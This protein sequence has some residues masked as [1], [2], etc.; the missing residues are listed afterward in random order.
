V[1]A[2][3]ERGA[4]TVKRR[5]AF[6]LAWGTCALT[7]VLTV[8]IVV[9]AVLSHRGFDYAS[10]SIVG[11]SSAVVGAVVASKRPANIVG[12]LFLFAALLSTSQELAAG[13]AVYGIL[14]DPSA[15][16]L[17][18]AAA[19]FSNAIEMVGPLLIFILIPLYF[20]TGRPVSRRWGLVAW[21]ALGVL[22]VVTLLVD[23]RYRRA[24]HPAAP[25]HP[26][27]HRPPLL[28][29]QIRRGADARNLLGEAARRDGL[30]RSGRRPGGGRCEDHAARTRQPVAARAGE[31]GVMTAPFFPVTLPVTFRRRPLCRVRTE[32]A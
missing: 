12:W 30:G 9:L 7:L 8:C 17:P 2:G 13:Y 24:V 14:A 27:V 29:Q 20:P 16:P 18:Y 5:A 1:V 31:G 25:P 6:R 4:A 23:P 26:G 32:C 21:L 3:E 19:W 10:F 11:V 15:V 22:P 28:P